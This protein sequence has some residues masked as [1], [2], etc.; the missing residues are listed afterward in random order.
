MCGFIGIIGKQA[1]NA[2]R[3]LYN[4]MI[5]I[6]HRGQDSAGI[7]TYDGDKFHLAKGGGLVRDVFNASN[8]MALDGNMGLGHVRYPTIGSGGTEDAQPLFVNVPW[9]IAMAHNGNVIN[10]DALRRELLN[11]NHR[12]LNSTCDVE[13]ILNVFASEIDKDKNGGISPEAVFRAAQGVFKRV[14]GSYSV[15]ALIAGGGMVA[16]RDPYGIKP[17]IM[18]ERLEN[19]GETSYCIASESVVLDLLDFHN[20]YDIQPAEVVYIDM[21]R[22][23][24]RKQFKS[25][26]HRPCIFEW[27]YFARP[28][29]FI[30]R[31]SV[32]KTRLRLGQSL[33]RK[34]KKTGIPVDVV[35]PVPESAR[36]AALAMA[37]ELGV[38]FREGLVKNRYIGRTFIMPGTTDRRRQVRHKLNP[39]QVEFEGKDVLI[40]DDSIVRGTTVKEIIQIARNA[41]A[42]KIYF[43]SYSAPLKFPCVYGIDMQTRHEFIA[44]D[45]DIEQIRKAIG[46]DYLLYQSY[47]AMLQAVKEGNPDIDNF[48]SACFSGEYP[49][50]DLP[51]DLME[52]LERERM[53]IQHQFVFTPSGKQPI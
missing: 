14:Q 19:N 20:T 6:Q 48:C 2:A 47:D 35:M 3:E 36:P 17:I 34:W 50:G 25:P 27:I 38:K 49:T 22:K 44:R 45:K 26:M 33:A 24:H 32:Y 13:A 23:V 11:D 7:I 8:T 51:P 53:S 31:I 4:G 1:T 18:G 30:D 12:Y 40:V 46:A 37:A 43:A 41:G 21:Q 15:V 5:A 52:S 42:K 9:G 39:I 29:S 10:Y 28:D 16:F